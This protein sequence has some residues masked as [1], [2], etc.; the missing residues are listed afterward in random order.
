MSLIGVPLAQQKSTIPSTSEVVLG[1]QVVMLRGGMRL[2]VSESRRLNALAIVVEAL[3]SGC[4]N[5]ALCS[6]LTGKLSSFACALWGKIGRTFLWPLY[7][8]QEGTLSQLSHRVRLALEW[9]QVA[10]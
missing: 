8:H 4:L 3:E 2:S 7:R 1:C 9:W 10:S 5:T 6:K